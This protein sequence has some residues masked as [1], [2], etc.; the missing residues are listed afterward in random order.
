M[1]SITILGSTGSIGV[2]TLDIISQ[3]RDEFS[4]FALT[5]HHKIE[6]LI[7]QCQQFQPQHV[8]IIDETA[9]QKF[10]AQMAI[11]KISCEVHVG[12]SALVAVAEH[13][14]VDYVM[15]AI[16]GAAGLLPSLAAANAGKRVLL[17]N[18]ES[19][20]ITG[21]LFMNAI[22]HSG[23]ELLPIDSE[24]NALYQSLPFKPFGQSLSEMGVKRLILTASGGPF[25]TFTPEQLVAVTPEQA[26][27]HP[28]WKMG[29]KISVD[30]ATMMNKGLEVIEAHWL[31]NAPV[32]QIDVMIHP[33]S[34]IHSMVEYTDG[35][36]M[37]ELGMPDMRTPIAYGLAWPQRITSGVKQLNLLEIGKLEFYKVDFAQFPCMKLAY[38]ALAQG[39]T[40]AVTLNAANEVA[41]EAF[42]QKRINFVQIAQVVETALGK[43][44][45]QPAN[46]L[47]IIL[48]VDAETRR[49]SEKTV[50]AF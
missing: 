6:K 11:H 26:V 8:V 40:A 22:K 24:H 39:G 17:A 28:N 19:L 13:S 36:V 15:A 2:N 25:R 1:K 47:E 16:L 43:I 14:E 9:A 10:R 29:Q 46:D 44:A 4:V 5:C 48:A 23:A 41:V 12:T 38:D 34:V 45:I 18:K 3:H 31:F 21:E 32:Q 20:V 27:A 37:A 49:L 42:L 33:Q 7:E 50:A 35:S 30:S